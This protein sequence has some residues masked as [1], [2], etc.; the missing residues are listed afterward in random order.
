VVKLLGPD[1][2]GMRAYERELAAYRA[3]HALQGSAVPQLLGDGRWDSGV[4]FIALRRLRGRTLAQVAAAG[5]GVLEPQVR[6][7]ALSAL[8]SVHAAA[9]GLLHGDI[10]LHN[11]M[12]LDSEEEQEEEGSVGAMAA[13]NM[14]G[15]EPAAASSASAA[16]ASP[17]AAGV[18]AAPA[19]GVDMRQQRQRPCTVAVI[20]FGRTRLHASIAQQQAER[21]ALEQLLQACSRTG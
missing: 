16:S 21:A 12:L 17:A 1:A 14:L 4:H 18:P 13:G 20:D 15:A 2:G 6:A 7:A 10:R 5:G 11:L 9:P 19:L 3:L 8:D